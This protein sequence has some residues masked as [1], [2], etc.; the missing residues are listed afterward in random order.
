VYRLADVVRALEHAVT[1]ST[2]SM[3]T[4]DRTFENWLLMA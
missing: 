1:S 2:P 3:K 4:N